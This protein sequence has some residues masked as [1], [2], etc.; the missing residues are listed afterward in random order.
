MINREIIYERNLTGSFM[1]IPIGIKAGLDEQIMLRRKLPGALSVEKAYMDGNGQYWYNIS[2]KQSL[3]TYCRMKEIGIAFIERLIVSICSEM[4][5]LEWNLIQTSC[6]MLDPELVFITNCNGEF[7]F[8]IYPA[9]SGGVE[10]EF[11]QLMEYLLTR[12][13]HKDAIAVKTAYGIYEK[14]L[15]DGYSLPDIRDSIMEA[16]RSVSMPDSLEKEENNIEKDTGIEVIVPERRQ[17]GKKD[18]IEQKAEKRKEKKNKEKTRKEKVQGKDWWKSIR[19]ILTEWGILESDDKSEIQNHSKKADT[20]PPAKKRR[21]PE[22]EVV[23]PEEEM[24]VAPEPVFRPTVCLS[25]YQSK[26]RGVL[27]YQGSDQLADIRI[28]A[29][30]S[31]VGYGKEAD[32][33]IQRDTISQLHARI[34]REEDTYYIEDLNST[35]GTFVN[36]EPLAYKE[37]RKLNSNDIVRF[38]DVRYRFG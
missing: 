36:D 34:D 1:K 23:Y 37:R 33:Q 19:K 21:E 17:H 8:T 29:G 22:A 31:C 30:M 27:M 2:G 7:I 25:S 3:D 5:I 32:I 16:K 35:N 20:K 24:Y 9:N 18:Y 11:Q 10:K 14:T 4:E 38:A 15:Q 13:D 12:V 6:L 28:E 26:P